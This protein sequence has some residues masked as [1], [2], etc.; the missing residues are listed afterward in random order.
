M[1]LR[2]EA[3]KLIGKNADSLTKLIMVNVIVFILANILSNIPGTRAWVDYVSLPSSLGLFIKYPWT[4]FTYMFVHVNFMH[5]LFNMLWLYWIGI[6]FSDFLGQ[7]RLVY[8]YILGGLAGGI[9]YLLTAPVLY[10]GGVYGMLIGASA[11][12]MAIIVAAAMLVP[13]YEI[14]LLF[15]GRVKLKY[16]ALAAFILSTLIDFSVNSGG[17]ISHVGGAIYGAVFLWQ[18]R[19]GVDISGGFAGFIKKIGSFFNREKRK[20]AKAAKSKITSSRDKQR[21]IDEILDK[22]SRAGYDSLSKE[23]KDF[24]FKSSKEN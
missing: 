1:S 6:I 13:D 15:F 14:M 12:V 21:R 3:D 16:L 8:T 19:K 22:I 11:G 24:L 20:S 18:Y 7:T 23:E 9:L 10:P 5:L 4:L 2:S 17:K